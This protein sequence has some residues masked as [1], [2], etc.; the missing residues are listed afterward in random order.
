MGITLC[1]AGKIKKLVYYCDNWAALG[2]NSDVII[3]VRT[4]KWIDL[5]KDD[6]VMLAKDFNNGYWC[7][8]ERTK[9]A[10]PIEKDIF[11]IRRSNANTR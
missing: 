3:K 6:I 5:D 8:R 11:T 1:T 10:S 4:K 2:N 7:D 9:Q